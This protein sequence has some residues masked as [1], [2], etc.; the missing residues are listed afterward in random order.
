MFNLIGPKRYDVPWH[1][2]EAQGWVAAADCVEV[3]S[4]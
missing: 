3:R 4:T 1:D 2:L